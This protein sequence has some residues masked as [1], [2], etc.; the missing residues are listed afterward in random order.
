MVNENRCVHLARVD[1]RHTAHNTA[2]AAGGGLAPLMR[3]L[4]S[5]AASSLQ[6]HIA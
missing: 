4:L 3:L 5:Q 6:R 2:A 1:A